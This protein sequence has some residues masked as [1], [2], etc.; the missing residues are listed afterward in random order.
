[1]EMN[2]LLMII[3]LAVLVEFIIERLKDVLPNSIGKLSLVP[4]YSLVG[5]IGIALIT[6]IDILANLGFETLAPV[7]FMITGI[8]IS[9]GSRAV[10]ELV[11]KLQ[12]SRTQQYEEN[13]I[14][15]AESEILKIVKEAKGTMVDDLKSNDIFS[16]AKKIEVKNI[17]FMRIKSLIP[18]D[19]Y[20]ALNKITGDADR[21]I[22]TTIEFFVELSKE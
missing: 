8:V 18:E 1:M 6:K 17:V 2:E 10:H 3:I 16:D 12:D 22:K 14:A 5:G 13:V 21:W 15:Y 9:G 19:K 11:A 4:Y 7:G 20:K